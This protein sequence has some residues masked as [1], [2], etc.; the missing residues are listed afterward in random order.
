[1]ILFSFYRF[2]MNVVLYTNRKIGHKFTIF[3]L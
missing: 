3:F 1:M 2:S